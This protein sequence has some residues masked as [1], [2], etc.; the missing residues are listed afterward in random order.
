VLATSKFWLVI[1][2]M[3]LTFLNSGV[4]YGWTGM[5][6]VLTK[7]GVYSQYPEGEQEE[8]FDLIMTIASFFTAGSGL[9]I[10]LLL[11]AVGPRYT[12]FAATMITIGGCFVFGW[13]LN[14][15]VGYAM[16]A[17]GGM[18]ILISSFRAAYL[19]PSQQSL[20]IGSISCLF[21]S[22]T[23]IFVVF[24]MLYET[25]GVSLK[26]LCVGYAA[27][28]LLLSLLLFW[29]WT[30]NPTFDR[31]SIKTDNEEE[32]ALL[33]VAGDLSTNA[34]EP[35][36]KPLVADI[37]F[38][39][40]LKSP[41]FVFIYFFCCVQMFR[42]NMFLGTAGNFLL[43]LGDAADNDYYS[44]FLASIIPLGFIFVPV[45]SFFL[46]RKG[47]ARS[48]YMVIAIGLAYGGLSMVKNLKV[49]LAT[50]FFFTFFRAALFSFVAAFNAKIFGPASVGRVT[51]ILYT[52][53]AILITLQ[54]PA[55]AATVHVF[56]N[57]YMPLHGLLTFLCAAC[58]PTVMIL[59]CYSKEVGL[60]EPFDDEEEEEDVEGGKAP[61]PG[62]PQS[63]SS[64]L[65][66]YSRGGTPSKRKRA[67]LVRSFSLGSEQSFVDAAERE[68]AEKLAADGGALA[69]GAQRREA[70]RQDFEA[71]HGVTT[72]G[73]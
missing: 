50:A 39:K 40:Q 10:G 37:P 16:F 4:I 48:A 18:G 66:N 19:F 30:L 54:Y 13:Q 20:V 65:S 43:A 42:S 27:L 53:T 7:E 28:T 5:R 23:V 59:Q 33:P 64:Q 8:K 47:F 2:V 46:D 44:K 71:E 25:Y 49:Q 69:P 11:D 70:R 35:G 31:L 60:P 45:I 32:E 73:T 61:T 36:A 57:N 62:T 38:G 56:D 63:F 34:T 55:T 51:G 58:I 6:L 72:Y 24:D 1:V 21:D 17:V 14:L 68:E 26:Q 22:S 3:L 29:L 12:A 9:F 41:E 15:T 67:G 52:T